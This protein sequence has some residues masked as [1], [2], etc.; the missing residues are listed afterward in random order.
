MIYR[1]IAMVIETATPGGARAIYNISVY[2]KP[3]VQALATSKPNLSPFLD[4][5]PELAEITTMSDMARLS[6]LAGVDLHDGHIIVYVL[7]RHRSHEF[8]ELLKEIDAYYP[9]DSLIR[10]ILD[11]H[12]SHISEEIGR[13]LAT[14][15]GRFVYVRTPN[16][17]SW[18]NLIEAVLSKNELNFP[19][20]FSGEF[21]AA[22]I[23]R[24]MTGNAQFNQRPIVFR[25]H[26]FGKPHEEMCL[27]S[28]N[29]VLYRV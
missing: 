4:D 28:R 23:E 5:M 19:T 16:H 11:K 7:E 22:L 17:G 8:V 10:I 27:F 26:N 14:R 9:P 29:G 24:I 2:E 6:I 25:W 20:L 13:Y 21:K 12:S 3:G 18:L 1:E 15:P